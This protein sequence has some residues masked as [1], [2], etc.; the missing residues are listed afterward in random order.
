M[1]WLSFVMVRVLLKCHV[2]SLTRPQFDWH[3]R[4]DQFMNL[5]NAS[6]SY[7]S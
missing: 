4:K 3:S 7:T 2:K 6:Y 1:V 5:I